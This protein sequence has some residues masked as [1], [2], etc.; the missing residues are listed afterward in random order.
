MKALF[1]QTAMVLSF[2]AVSSMAVANA[3]LKVAY[4]DL[5]QALQSVDAGKKAKSQLEKD[6]AAKKNELE[7]E[8]ASLQKEAEEFEKKAAI[9]NEAARGKKQAE[10]QKKLMEFQRK[11][12]E[13]QMTLQNQERSLT[14]PL[15]DELRSIIEGL[16]KE[17]GYS[18]ILEKNEGAVLYAETGSDLTDE[19]VKRFNAK[20]GK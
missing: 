10:L 15:I 1:V 9:L 17:R 5:Q 14:K 20:R 18:L 3:S 6:V 7:K 4:V 8:Q 12:A 13:T 16:G 2:F 11:A 19:V